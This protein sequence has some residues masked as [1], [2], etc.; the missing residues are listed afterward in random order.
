[1]S[2]IGALNIGRTALATQQAALQVTGNNIANAGNEDYS[3]ETV[4]VSP[5]SDQQLSPGQFIGTGAELTAIQR[6]VDASLDGR[7][8]SATSD[9]EAATTTQQWTGRI[10]SVFNALSDQD[11]SSQFSKFFNAWSDLANQPADVG[12]RRVVLQAGVSVANSFN[13]L[14]TDLTSLA[15]DASQSLVSTTK[16]ADALASTVAQLNGQISVSEGGTGGSA[17]GLRDQ[18]DAALKQLAQLININT[19]EQPNGMVNVYVGSEPLVV[20]TQ[21]RGLSTQINSTGANTPATTQVVI[22]QD[23]GAVTVTSGQLGGLLQAQTT[24]D[25]TINNINRLA[26]NLIFEVNKLHASGQGTQ[27]ITSA[28][29]TAQAQNPNVPLNAAG[30]L[31]Y[32]PVNGSFVVHVHDQSTGL[33]T[34]TLIKVDLDGQGGNDTTLNSLTAS[35]AAVPGITANVVAGKLQLSATN[36]GTDI[37]FSQDTSGTLAALGINTFFSG[38]DARTIGMNTAIQTNPNLLAAAKNGD[39]TD[40]QTA[41]AISNLETQPIAALNGS[42]KD[43]Y[44][45][46][47]EKLATTAAA[48][49]DNADA[50]TAVQQT[51]EGQRQALSGVSLDEEATNLIQQQRAFQGAARLISAVDDM[52]KTLLAIT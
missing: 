6:Q 15:S 31:A 14:N 13:S 20:N 16:A 18:R 25:K 33:T 44:Q 40:N 39:A 17:N 30:V 9:A 48:A 27:G 2:L 37:S 42:L 29:S 36:P 11:L 34:S 50:A 43:V 38:F 23:H 8:R 7:I 12:L 22:T 51:L 10:Q 1:M 24:A 46:T 3:R 52:M 45:N 21:N 5:T 26:S 47:V 28:V 41:V 32:Q 35:L 19:S 4:S 49:S